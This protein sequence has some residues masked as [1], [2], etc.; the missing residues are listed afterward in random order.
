MKKQANK[1]STSNPKK[2]TNSGVYPLGQPVVV[3]TEY[4]GVFFGYVKDCSN[5][6][7]SIELTEVCN[8]RSWSEDMRGFVGLIKMGPSDSC[9]I[10][11]SADSMTLWKIT[12]CSPVSEAVATRWIIASQSK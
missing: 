7:E 4:R 9:K 3:T 2:R 1:K 6:P 8:C 10:G 12:S 11:P 5:L